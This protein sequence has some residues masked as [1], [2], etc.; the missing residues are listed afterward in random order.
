[1]KFFLLSVGWWNFA[2]SLLMIG[3]FHEGFGRKI[4]N[5]W[6]KIFRQTFTLDY[7]SRLWL[8][9]AVL[10]NV[11]FGLIN[12]MA[13]EWNYPD[14]MRFLVVGDILGYGCF[15]MLAVRAFLRKQLGAGAYSVF[16]IFTGWLVWGI[17]TLFV[18]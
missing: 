18:Q 3:F 2:G 15:Y 7:W 9:W 12:I 6:T 5:D 11:F 1:M 16:I 13:V 4:L 8:F 17:S 10:F 14:V